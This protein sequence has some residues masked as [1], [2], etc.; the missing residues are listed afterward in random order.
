MKTRCAIILLIV[1]TSVSTAQT[2]DSSEA[3]VKTSRQRV[4]QDRNAIRNLGFKLDDSAFEMLE[5][6]SDEQLREMKRTALDS[7]IGSALDLIGKAAEAG[8]QPRPTLPNGIAS[9]NPVTVQPFIKELENPQGSFDNPFDLN[10]DV[11]GNVP[12]L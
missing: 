7:L 4:Q 12:K 1:T 5:K 6:A 9:L 3:A 11:E 8:L 10:S 2:C